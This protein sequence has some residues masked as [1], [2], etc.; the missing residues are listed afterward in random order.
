MDF[1]SVF[2]EYYQLYRAEATVPTSDDDE[3]TIAMTFAN[4]ALNRW[5]NYDGTYWRELFTTNQDDGSG[6]QTVVTSQKTYDGPDNMREVG[7]FIKILDSS[8]NTIQRYNLIEPHEVQ[9]KG[10]LG[11]FAYFTGD[12][13]TGWTL[14]LNPSPPSSLSGKDI[15]YIYYK[16]PTEYTTGTDISECP[17]PRFLIHHMLSNR[18][19]ASR[20]WDAYQTA[21]RDAEDALKLMKLDNDSGSYA[22]PWKLV[23]NSGSIWGR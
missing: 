9:F 8:S 21:L 13:N 5:A 2:T 16:N 6:A 20:N 17:N 3:Y 11:T 23:D 14:H 22:N 18:F 15:D 7:G 4:N 12:P 1:D 19:R 10:D